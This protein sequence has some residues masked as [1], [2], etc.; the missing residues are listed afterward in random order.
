MET[1]L[2]RGLPKCTVHLSFGQAKSRFGQV[3]CVVGSGSVQIFDNITKFV[4]SFESGCF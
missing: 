4:F 1:M 2:T 3:K